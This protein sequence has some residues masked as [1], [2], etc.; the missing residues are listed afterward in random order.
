MWRCRYLILLLATT[1]P[2]FAVGPAKS[3]SRSTPAGEP[4]S[5]ANGLGSFDGLDRDARHWRDD[6]ANSSRWQEEQLES[7]AGRLWCVSGSGEPLNGMPLF[8]MSKRWDDVA[9][10]Y[11]AL[12]AS[13][14]RAGDFPAF[15]RHNLDHTAG[16]MGDDRHAQALIAIHYW[17]ELDSLPWERDVLGAIPR[18]RD[19]EP[20]AGADRL[21]WQEWAGR[22]G[23][24]LRLL[25]VGP[26]IS[27]GAQLLDELAR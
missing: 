8:E 4:Y 9:A 24:T 5:L 13:G 12:A 6:L 10:A 25:R 2:A 21:V 16:R 20:V 23:G 17:V 26:W 11:R 27:S 1:L 22:V 15:V 3:P 14:R 18:H 19:D 7:C